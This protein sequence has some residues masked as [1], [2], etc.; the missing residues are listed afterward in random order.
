MS[1]L[2]NTS[3]DI[4][5]NDNIISKY[6]E[7]IGTCWKKCFNK[8][9]ICELFIFTT[10]IKGLYTWRCYWNDYYKSEGVLYTL[11]DLLFLLDNYDLK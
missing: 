11:N 1:I 6:V 4:S 7:N 5:L 8:D 9:F 3:I 2:N 10:S